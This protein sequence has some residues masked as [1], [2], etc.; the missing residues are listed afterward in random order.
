MIRSVHQLLYGVLGLILGS[1]TSSVYALTE[2]D[3]TNQSGVQGTSSQ[4]EVN[5]INNTNDVLVLPK[6]MIVTKT[7]DD[8]GLSTPTQVGDQI[9]YQIT[10]EN[11]GLLS[12]TN[13]QWAD[14]IIPAASMV[15]NGD[16]DFDNEL[17]ADEIWI[18]TG[19][20]SITQSDL[21]TNGGG[22][23]YIENTITV[24]T[25][26]LPDISDN[27]EVAIVQE[28]SLAITK[29][30][31]ISSIGAPITLNYEIEVS[32]TGNVS[33]TTVNVVDTL[34][35]G[36]TGS[37]IGPLTDTGAPAVLDVGETWKYTIS[38]A[39]DQ[40]T[41][42]AGTTQINTVVVTSAETGTTAVSD[43][44][45]TDIVN[46]PSFTLEKSVDL[47][48]INQP[49]TLSYTIEIS[50]NGNRTLNNVQLND[51]LPDGTVATLVGPINDI[52]IT[53]AIDVGETW[54]YTGTYIA[55]QTDIDAGN[56]LI[57]TISVTF[58][59]TGSSPIDATATTTIEQTPSLEVSK[60]VDQGTIT[61]PATL[62]YVITVKN[63]GNTTLDNIALNDTLPDST[64]AVVT[65][66]A[67]DVGVVGS[68]DVG[69]SWEYTTTY[70][71]SQTDI[72]SGLPL[73]N[74]VT[75]TSDQTTPT[76]KTA[77]AVS[78][79]A[80]T[81]SFTVSK[82]VD[83]AS[84]SEPS[85]L[86]YQIEV[87][88]TGNTSLTD[89]ELL[90][91]MPDGSTGV[92]AGPTGDGL[93]PS[94]LDVGETW[95]FT[96]QYS[97]TQDNINEGSNLIN[98]VDA[99]TAETDDQSAIATTAVSQTPDL[100]IAKQSV[101]TIFQSIGDQ[102]NF[103][104]LITNNG[105]VLLSNLIVDDPLADIG[106][107]NCAQAQP[108]QLA[109]GQSLACSAFITVTADH[110][111]ATELSN[112]ATVNGQDSTGTAISANSEIVTVL[113][114]R[115][116]PV[117]TDE[118]QVNNVSTSP[119]LFTAAA[120]DTD[121]NGDIDV[122][123]AAFT[124]P[125][126]ID[127]DADGDT[128]TLIVSG[129]G[130][131]TFD[132]TTGEAQFTPAPGFTAD[133]TPVT[134][135]V[136]DATTLVSNTALLIADYPQSA[137]VAV[138]D[139]LQNSLPPLPSNP[140]TVNVLLANG[141]AVDSDPENDLLASTISFT[142]TNAIDTDGDGDNDNLLV[143]TEGSW[144][145]DALANVTFTPAAGFL[146][147]P[148]PIKY[149]V[150]DVTSLVSNEA[151]I[152]IEYPQ[153]APVAV[154][155]QRLEQPLGQP[156]VISVLDNDSDVENNID[157]ATV[158]IV[159]P[160]TGL[161]VDTIVVPNEG[162]WTV[163]TTSG[164]ISFL[165]EPDFLDDPTPISYRVFDS[166]GVPSNW[167][168]VTITFEEP[169]G[170]AGVV[171]LDRDRDGVVDADE[172]RKAGWTLRVI[173]S[174]GVEVTSTITDANGEYSV[175]GLIPDAYV[176]EF[177]NVN[178]VFM[179]SQDTNGVVLS[180]E[181]INLPLPVDPGGV[182]YDSISRLPVEGI[183]LS[184]VNESGIEV[185]PSC[186]EANQQGQTTSV[187]GLYSFN[188]YVGQH[189]SCPVN[190]IYEII[191]AAAPAEYYSNF[192]S[193]IRQQG[194]S[195]CGS[196][197]LGCAVSSTFDAAATE[198]GCTVDALPGTSACEVQSQPN[199][200]QDSDD[201]RYFVEFLFNAGDRG[202]V[203]NH[204]PVDL[205][206]NETEI[207]LSK[208]VNK[209]T[210]SIG[211]IL[212]YTITA[213]NTNTVPA[214]DVSIIDTPPAGFSFVPS[215]VRLHRSGVDGAFD[216][217]DDQSS[218]LASN[219]TNPIEFTAIDIDQE[220]T[221][222]ITY[223][224]RVGVGVVA[225]SYVNSARAT[226]PFGI[227]SNVVS[228]SVEV[229]SDPV[230]GQATLIG[231]VFHDRDEDGIQ[232]SANASGVTLG[233]DYYGWSNLGLPPLPGRQDVNQDPAQHSIVVNMP[234]GENNNFKLSTQEGSRIVVD[235]D[236]NVTETHVGDKARGFN[237]QDIRICT[238][239]TTAIPTD[240]QGI[241]AAGDS[242]ADVLKIV[243]SNHGINESGI[244][245]ARLATV[246]GLII[247]TDAYGRYSIPDVDA[248][249]TDFGQNIVLK[250]DPASLPNGSRFT[251][252]NPYVLRIISS[253]LNRINF[254]VA[255]PERDR[256]DNATQLQCDQNPNTSKGKSVEV[257]LGAV[258]FDSN[259]AAVRADQRGIVTDIINK[260]LTYGGG[261]ILIEAHT[262]SRG[263]YQANLRLAE[264]R[265]ATIERILQDELGND[266][267]K[268][269]SV[270]VNPAAYQESTK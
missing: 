155:D 102:I 83:Q 150:S 259:D 114:E 186:L 270:E 254:G 64:V 248:G 169:A 246:T 130:T 35:D 33:L 47:V 125:N 168:T 264:Q 167:A 75:V 236:G 158:R 230:L 241:P 36:T 147:D 188:V 208:G 58:D 193:I 88:N 235:E 211:D 228:V 156:V 161:S 152:T 232:D 227:A 8:S 256:Y 109:P 73:T 223:L 22:D 159:D 225:G 251:T 12:L 257:K 163:D 226:G 268:Y 255:I 199:A 174:S 11:I 54:E 27:V 113:M 13:V 178:G 269:V 76:F 41:I 80:Q 238:E 165:A 144:T 153:T 145:V 221:I 252:E 90:D 62:A 242:I 175:T 205:R 111:I 132:N 166:T 196:P 31:D 260:I 198:F 120:D 68:L 50:N 127:T 195:S 129:E 233:S 65:G 20:Y 149:T 126:A 137:P 94:I 105:N 253:T 157:P 79:I 190:S 38:F 177:Y 138:D 25:D 81:P 210:V 182:V 46:T 244:P 172:S 34:P 28:P 170:L 192:S 258:F 86:G 140:T 267:M 183:T 91:T 9:D 107:T 218:F 56:D 204:L 216:T 209:R 84:I 191:I 201:T 173:N 142:D 67:T 55:S 59:E 154:D 10:I 222:R 265:A 180:G 16:A 85:V 95:V 213:E 15:L 249:I 115:I 44:A 123:S 247:E 176:V 71:V 214:N 108:F 93:T 78:I 263:R 104:L 89:V 53:A 40:T 219:D 21:D 131:W 143:T 185:D 43:S 160:V 29:N 96:T 224:M 51:T 133:P 32:N 207:L 103:D 121:I 135:I 171:W 82:I 99:T 97:A 200:P 261:R 24:S 101:E 7:A 61:A 162:V 39:V 215:S 151:T 245:G 234:I 203:F 141:G 239:K 1:G 116:P 164:E 5:V 212:Q 187:D 197:S 119:T 146:A 3:F 118:T 139:F 30:V 4:Y 231:K 49:E 220:E 262:D 57:N 92:L 48:A 112:Q 122:S 100:V 37:L 266:Q 229:I 74:N 136:S 87:S 66:P 202:V 134:Y 179:D 14:S 106:S 250:V 42:D 60:T 52:G 26:E 45:E 184:L 17:D 18:V 243:I 148:T 69:E 110:M 98:Q 128:D 181:M 23:G 189:A 217:E 70:S 19:S 6:G 77:N 2:S 72:D 240:K 194:A 63:T 124:N 117:A 237:S 206:A